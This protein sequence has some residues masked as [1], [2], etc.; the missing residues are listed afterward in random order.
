[1]KQIA[2]LALLISL[3]AFTAE[4]AISNTGDVINLDQQDH[5]LCELAHAIDTVSTLAG[6]TSVTTA[7]V[8]AADE[9]S[10]FHAVFLLIYTSYHPEQEKIIQPFTQRMIAW[11]QQSIQD[12]WSDIWDIHIQILAGLS[13]NIGA[14]IC[15]MLEWNIQHPDKRVNYQEWRSL[16]RPGSF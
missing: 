3:F 1:M 4:A 10:P 2:I 6:W 16:T 15:N 12:G 8:Q 7:M 11:Q 9:Y 13:K 5:A 14:D